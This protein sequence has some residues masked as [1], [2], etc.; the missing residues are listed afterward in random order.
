MKYYEG[1]WLLT[2]RKYSIFT[3]DFRKYK[4]KL[5]HSEN[6]IPELDIQSGFRKFSGFCKRIRSISRYSTFNFSFDFIRKKEESITRKTMVF[7]PEYKCE[8]IRE[9]GS[10]KLYIH[11]VNQ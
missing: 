6:C 4:D 1:T 5:S 7:T 11:K 3:W 10:H 2:K 9:A 8:V